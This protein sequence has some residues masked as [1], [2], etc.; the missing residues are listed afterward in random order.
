M[1]SICL[2]SMNV[3]YGK[4]NSELT[5]YLW[6]QGL[7]I[8]FDVRQQGEYWATDRWGRGMIERGGVDRDHFIKRGFFG[9]VQFTMII[10]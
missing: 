7:V 2:L 1:N 9:V 5:N 10:D 3:G 4:R 8:V 6:D